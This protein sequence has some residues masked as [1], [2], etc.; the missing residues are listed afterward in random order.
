MFLISDNVDTQT[1]MWLA[2]VESVVVHKKH[3]V[4]EILN[5]V[6]NDQDIG[7]VIITEI[8][9]D[10][11]AELVLEYKLKKRLPLILEIPD[12]HGKRKKEDFATKYIKESLGIKIVKE[13]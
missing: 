5:K 1:G 4:E 13:V 7:I 2:G 11:A 6:M 12:R 10:M 9:A 3:E 8:L